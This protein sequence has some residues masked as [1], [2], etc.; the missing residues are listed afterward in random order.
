MKAYVEAG[1]GSC[2][3]IEWVRLGGWVAFDF[4]SEDGRLLCFSDDFANIFT[5]RLRLF[6][7]RTWNS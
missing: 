6:F 4:F 7:G 2:D 1:M 3:W 5:P